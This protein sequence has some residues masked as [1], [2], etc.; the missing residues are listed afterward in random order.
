[1]SWL[2]L[3]GAVLATAIGAGAFWMGRASIP[4]ESARPGVR[5]TPGVILAI[6][7]VAKLETTVFHVEKVVE[8]TDAQSRLWGLVKAH[9]VVLLVAVGDVVAGVDLAKVAATDVRT[10][11]ATHAVS[12]KLPAPEIVTAVLDEKATHVYR[13]S[14]ELLAT[15]NEQLEGEARRTA[16]VEMRNA[17][18]EEGILDR[19]R[20]SAESTVR[21][22]LR[23]LGYER[24]EIDWG[25]RG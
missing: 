25:D 3:A 5:S 23:T 21:A 1:V 2:L 12:V 11:E 8:A 24:I 19:A 16:E 6:H 20:A 4:A 9:D 7:D 10:D 18:L 14:T 22:L 13:R 17:A 15:R